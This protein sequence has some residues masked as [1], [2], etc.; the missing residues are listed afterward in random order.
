MTRKRMHVCIYTTGNGNAMEK[1][2]FLKVY[3]NGRHRHFNPGKERQEWR[4]EERE[5]ASAKTFL[6][7]TI[8]LP[9]V[10]KVK[11]GVLDVS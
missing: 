2:N 8:I 9:G 3:N 5:R 1:R 6:A 11:M 10:E 4:G 7:A